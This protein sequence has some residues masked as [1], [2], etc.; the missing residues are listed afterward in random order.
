[1]TNAIFDYLL[2][3]VSLSLTTAGQLLQKRAAVLA[4]SGEEH[5]LFI[6]RLFFHRQTYWA[7]LLL[8]AGTL[9]WLMVLLRLEVS[10]AV[11]FLSLGFVLVALVSKFVL[12][13][14]LSGKRWLGIMLIV[15]G[16]G[17][18]CSS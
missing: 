13:E 14:T 1:M 4:E 16:L 9:V 12:R 5:N 7:I 6:V 15:A 17:M 10:K 11:P 8:A 18:V 3:G 2:I